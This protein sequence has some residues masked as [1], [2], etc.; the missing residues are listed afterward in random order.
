LIRL[1]ILSGRTEAKA[2]KE[3]NID[4]KQ[5]SSSLRTL[6]RGLDVLDCFCRGTAK[7]TLTD[8]TD[9]TGLNPSTAFRILATLEKRDY[10]KRD[11]E[12]KK[13]QLGTQVLSL[14]LP[15]LEAYDLRSIA[16]P[17]MQ[18]LFDTSNESVSL[19]L[20]LGEYRL[21]LE[22]IETTYA[23]RRV[24]NIGER[25]PINKGA[26]GKALLAWMAEDKL[27]QLMKKG[28]EI[29]SGDL[30]K[31]RERGYA[32]SVGER[33]K[34]VS[35]VAAPLFDSGGKI[36]ASLSIAAPEI[37]FS[38]EIMDRTAPL[39]VRAAEQISAALGYKK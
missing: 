36:V 28:L 7:L 17:Y 13:Y 16:K 20:P 34:G 38:R 31:I 3:N 9:L 5:V 21:C 24:I 18:E 27:K 14:I 33:E 35:A 19:Y 2:L 15:S 6:E 30:K 11:A 1:T 12:T 25:L 37:R 8:I 10:L 32:M 26:G 39:V 4:G 23:L 29:P 22:R